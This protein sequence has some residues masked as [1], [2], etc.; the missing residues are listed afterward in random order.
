MRL[1]LGALLAISLANGLLGCS[2][3]DD[4]GAADTGRRDTGACVE[5]DVGPAFPDPDAADTAPDV[6]DAGDTAPEV[7]DASDA[8]DATD[9]SDA[10]DGDAHDA[11]DAAD[12]ADTADATFGDAS[13]A[14]A[15]VADATASDAAD[16][17]DVDAFET[18]PDMFDAGAPVARSEIDD[19][20]QF[21]CAFTSC[22]G[23]VPQGVGGLFM[24]PA[25]SDWYP[26]VVNAKPDEIS[27]FVI[28][29]PYDPA[30]S[31][32]VHKVVGDNC[33]YTKSCKDKDC[34]DQMPQAN[35]P[36]DPSDIDKIVRWIRQGAKP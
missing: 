11:A 30:G 10:S 1:F 23:R 8:S 20:I 14:G 16:A 28:V 33:L 27:S 19:I 6:T 17:A 24:N 32:L 21:S 3:D 22:H 26:N 31:W 13:D 7:G 25:V 36:L 5:I 9:S 4:D 18:T 29:K 34:G 12:S 15:D 2:G 35:D